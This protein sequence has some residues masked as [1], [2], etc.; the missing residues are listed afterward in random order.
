MYFF[1]KVMISA[2]IIAGVTKLS[3]T[4]IVG[5][6][7]IKSLPI[8]SLM[9]FFIMKYEG[10]TDREIGAMSWDILYLVIPSLILFIALPVLMT[11]GLGFYIYMSI[12]TV[13]MC[14]GYAITLRVI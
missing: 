14:A 1:V 10:R 3:E 9:V 4:N 8:T 5:G 13:L 2:V 11:K 6:A 12:S 7:L